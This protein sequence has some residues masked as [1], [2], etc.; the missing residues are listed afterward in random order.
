MSYYVDLLTLPSPTR[1][2]AAKE[3]PMIDY[4]N[5]PQTNSADKPVGDDMILPFQL[6]RAGMR[7]RVARLDA[8]LDTILTQHNYPPA[9]G[10]LV[11]EAVLLTALIGQA[12][13][14]RW[15]FSLQIRG[16]GPV[17]LIATDY[18]APEEPGMPGEIRAFASYDEEAVAQAQG[19]AFDLLGEGVFGVTIDQ[20][21]DMSP[22]QGVT[23][24]TGDSLSACAETYF[25]QSE[26]LATRFMIEAAQE[27][28]TG[29]TQQWRA[30]GVM[31]QQLPGEGGHTPDAPSGED[32]L[33]TGD[34]IAVIGDREE[35]W[36]RVAIL[37]ST[38]ETIELIGPH[39]SPENLLIRLFHEEG[40]RVYEP[41]A[42]A[43]GCTC[44]ADRVRDALADYSAEDLSDMVTENGDIV[45]DCQFCGAHYSFGT[46]ELGTGPA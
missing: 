11:A 20:G 41:Q 24:L 13:K 9:V 44:S 42:I 8:T 1:H 30:G 29:G 6:D 28:S 43:F 14:L 46:S 22:Y 2:H 21:P 36:S 10:A 40:P 3:H 45:A 15:R 4:P 17:R 33:M 39:V 25:A 19:D 38:V 35:D 31:I 7:G 16:A 32:G 18:F 5:A 23:P 12:V 27:M 26:Q 37:L 34:D